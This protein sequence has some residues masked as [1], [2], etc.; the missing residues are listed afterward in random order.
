MTQ[1]DHLKL[2]KAGFTI[3][4]RDYQR[5]VIKCKMGERTQWHDLE[6]GFAFKAA[7]DRKAKELLELPNCVEN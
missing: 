5:L 4:R 7:L 2:L 6:K 1:N 3:I